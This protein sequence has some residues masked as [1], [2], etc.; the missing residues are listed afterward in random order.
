[1]S[2]ADE[3]TKTNKN[4]EKSNFNKIYN[5]VYEGDDIDTF[6]K[7]RFYYNNSIFN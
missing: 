1:M 2:K 3:I 6:I 4:K 5:N 7:G